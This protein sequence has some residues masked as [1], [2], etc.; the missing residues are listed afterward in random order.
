[1]RPGLHACSLKAP[2]SLHGSPDFQDCD[3]KLQRFSHS[4][5]E[6]SGLLIRS[7]KDT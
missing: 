6:L 1:M 2:E 3:A 7:N 5:K 4:V